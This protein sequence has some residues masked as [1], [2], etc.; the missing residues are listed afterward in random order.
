MTSHLKLHQRASLMVALALTAVMVWPTTGSV[1]QV[2][3][4]IT[5]SGLGTTLN[6]STSVPCVGGTCDITGG[7]RSGSNLFHSFGLFSVGEGDVAN[8]LN[9]TLTPTS[10]IIGRVTGGNPSKKKKAPD[11]FSPS[12]IERLATSSATKQD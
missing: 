11:P 1:A 10:N 3:T 12:V 6:G 4:N 7:T 2:T 9:D 5:S 8:F